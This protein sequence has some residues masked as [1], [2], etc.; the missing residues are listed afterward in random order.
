[1]SNPSGVF[2]PHLPWPFNLKHHGMNDIPKDLDKLY[3]QSHNNIRKRY[4]SEERRST[5]DYIHEVELLKESKNKNSIFKRFVRH[6]SL[7][8]TEM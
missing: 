3:F 7:K 8:D 5:I 6:C 1:M 4:S 2:N